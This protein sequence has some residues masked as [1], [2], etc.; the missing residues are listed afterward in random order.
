MSEY[1]T[2]VNWPD[3]V[4]LTDNDKYDEARTIRIVF[5]D[6]LMSSGGYYSV[7]QGEENIFEGDF[8]SAKREA[9]N[10]QGNN[11]RPIEREVTA[12]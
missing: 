8:Y 2:S 4:K 11:G 7:W 9:I 5:V 6:N 3:S 10:A 1:I 12:I